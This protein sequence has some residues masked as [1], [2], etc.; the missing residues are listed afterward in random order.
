VRGDEYKTA[1]QSIYV[2]PGTHAVLKERVVTHGEMAASSFNAALK[3]LTDRGI[4]DRSSEGK[5]TL[6]EW[7][8]TAATPTGRLDQQTRGGHPE[9]MKP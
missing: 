8:D 2:V 3:N 5:G 6:Y 9:P 7:T 1:G 4:L